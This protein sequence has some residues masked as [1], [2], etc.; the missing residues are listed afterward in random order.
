MKL[1]KKVQRA[2]TLG[3]VLAVFLFAIPSNA[4]A[5]GASPPAESVCMQALERC[6]FD[7]LVAFFTGGPMAGAGYSV[8][9]LMGY[10][11]CE[12]YIF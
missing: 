6:M 11:F 12:R 3:C 5:Q 9:C 1:T 2:L 4:K 7:A 10:E 8:S